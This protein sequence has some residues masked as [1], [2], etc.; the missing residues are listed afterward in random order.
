MDYSSRCHLINICI[1]C[2]D[3]SSL[4]LSTVADG[5]KRPSLERV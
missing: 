5:G 3:G 1:H 4:I 2:G